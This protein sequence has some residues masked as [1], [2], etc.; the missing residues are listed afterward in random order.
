MKVL[1]LLAA[2]FFGVGGVATAG[3]TVDCEVSNSD[4]LCTSWVMAN[5]T[6]DPLLVNM[7]VTG[8]LTESAKYGLWSFLV[9]CFFWVV[10]YVTRRIVQSIGMVSRIGG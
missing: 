2:I 1:C 10:G 4:G 7:G 8:S 3:V 9:I 6:D 5:D